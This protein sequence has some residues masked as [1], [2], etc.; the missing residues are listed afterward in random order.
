MIEESRQVY[1]MNRKMEE[2][3][4]ENVVSESEDSDPEE[5]VTVNDVLG[6]ESRELI[7]KKVK[8]LR[9]QATREAAKKIEAERFLKRKRSKHVGTILK[10]YPNIGSDIENFAKSRGVDAEAWKRTGVLTFDGNRKVQQKVTFSRIKDHLEEKYETKFSY[11][12]IVQMCVARNRRRKASANY[13]GVAKVTCRRARKG[14]EI[15]YNP[16]SHWSNAFYQGL[17]TVQ[18][19]DGRDKLLLNRDDLS[20]FRLDTMCTS[21]KAPTHCMQ[22]QPAL[23]TKTDYQA[24]YHN[25]LQTTSYNFTAS[26]NTGEVCVG[27][28]KSAAI[29]LKG[30]SQHLVDFM[31]LEQKD[32]IRHVFQNMETDKAKEI[33]CIWVDSGGDEALYHDEIQF[34]SGH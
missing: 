27:V 6:A 24:R 15:K 14:F 3:N 30:P 7:S 20:A 5:W 31:F 18:Y 32:E 16:D 33:E 13:K 1:L 19:K 28:V 4:D 11:G 29:H 9:K 8:S 25:T 17:D 2:M 12:T 23:T 10:K 21:N 26:E 34:W 22:G